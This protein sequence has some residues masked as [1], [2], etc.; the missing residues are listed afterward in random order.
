MLSQEPRQP[1]AGGSKRSL[2]LA[3]RRIRILFGEVYVEIT[4]IDRPE[5]FSDR[6]EIHGQGET[7]RHEK[8]LSDHTYNSSLLFICKGAAV[9]VSVL[10][11][12]RSWMAR[13]ARHATFLTLAP[14]SICFDSHF[15]RDLL[16]CI[17]RK[18]VWHL[19]TPEDRFNLSKYWAESICRCGRISWQ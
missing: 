15:T 9:L 2:V 10:R 1:A 11:W 5:K 17:I 19:E 18:A 16:D 14:Q 8:L 7:M 4:V 6:T 12:L 13:T 3:K